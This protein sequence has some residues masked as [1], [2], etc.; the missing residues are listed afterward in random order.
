VAVRADLHRAVGKLIT[1][2]VA[3]YAVDAEYSRLISEGTMSG[4]TLFKDNARDLPQLIS[5]V[6]SLLRLGGGTREFFVMV[7]Q[8]GGAVQRF[9]EVLT[10]LPSP[11]ALAGQPD[12][13]V[14][15]SLMGASARQLRLLGVN[16]VL[17]PVLDINS[18][19][20]NP[21]IGTRSFGADRRRVVEVA[22]AVAA[23]YLD[24][25]VLPVGKHFPGHGDTFEDSHLALAV[26]HADKQTLEDREF[27]PFRQV[28]ADLPAMLVGHIWL[29]EYEQ[30]ALPASLSERLIEGML[31]RDL[32]YDGFVMSDDMPV[33]RAIVDHWGLQEAAVLAVN[34]GLDNLLISGTPAQIEGVHQALFD[35]VKAGE[36]SEARLESALRRRATA[37]ALCSDERPASLGERERALM[38]EVSAGNLMAEEVSARCHATVRGVVPNIVGESDDWVLVVPDH[39]RYRLDLL[40]YLSSHLRPGA[41]ALRERR[42]P[43]RPTPDQIQ[44]VATFVGGRKCLLITFRALLNDGQMALARAIAGIYGGVAPGLLVAADVPYELLELPEWPNA[45]ATFDPSPLAMQSL[46]SVLTGA[47]RTSGAL[48]LAACPPY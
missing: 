4:V 14:V 32:A 16:C 33:M 34:A 31:R 12:L 45:V 18:N 10:P 47:A 41:P 43:L 39:P 8:E 3:G 20:R 40:T 5:L 2:K 46:A 19:P 35:A 21:I 17:A 44:D 29:T 48:A 1:G 23:A 37:L 38:H 24:E 9:D 26:V 13:G 36:I 11:M 27:Y 6:D 25:G 7:D 15:R 42:Y 22:R 30:E 28:V